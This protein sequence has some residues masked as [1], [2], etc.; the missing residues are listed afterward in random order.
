MHHLG[1]HTSIAGGLS[2]AIVRSRTFQGTALQIFSKNNNQWDAPPIT[3]EALASWH[4][5]APEIGLENIAIHDSY[6]INLCSPDPTTYRRSLKAFIDEHQRAEALGIRILNFHPGAAMTRSRDEAITIVAKQINKAHQ[7][8]KGFKTISTIE[9]TAGQGSTL[10][11]TFD[12]VAAIMELVDDQERVGVCI[13]TCH[14]F[15]AGYDIRTHKE[16]LATMREF[17]RT[18]GIDRLKLMHLND[19]KTDFGSRV[20]RHAHIGQ[21]KIGEGAFRSI[22]RD[23]RLRSIPMVIETPKGKDLAEDIENIGL[24]R[25]LAE[26]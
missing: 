3:S 1:A 25:R 16:Y 14:I 12:E 2:N 7:A 22:M 20:D 15:A 21:G 8:T 6:L 5:L 11:Y 13:D 18:I 17:D 19:S 26:A 9:T 24:L 4:E 23:R 10:G